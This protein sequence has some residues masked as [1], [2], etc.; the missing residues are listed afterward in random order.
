VFY[1]VGY[2]PKPELSFGPAL[3]LG[4]PSLG[5]LLDVK[6][7][8][9]IAPADLARRLQDVTLDGIDFLGAASLR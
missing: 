5:E 8:D 6:L 9:R 2:H 7:I 1:S 4:I 3:G